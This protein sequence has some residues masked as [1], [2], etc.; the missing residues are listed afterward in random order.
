ME[1]VIFSLRQVW[2]RFGTFEGVSRVG[3]WCILRKLGIGRVAI[4]F[5]KSMHGNARSRVKLKGS[6]GHDF[7]VQRG[8]HQGSV[9]SSLLIIKV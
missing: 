5:I 7:L 3:I 9:L 6:L 4:R 2:K 1:D 8:L